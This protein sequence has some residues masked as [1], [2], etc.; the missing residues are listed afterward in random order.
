MLQFQHRICSTKCFAILL[1]LGFLT[2]GFG[3]DGRASLIPN[4]DE[5]LRKTSTAFAADAAQRTYPADAP[6][7]GDAVGRVEVSYGIKAMELANLSEEDWNNVE[8]WVNHEY[9]VFVPLIPKKKDGEG[10]RHL[11]FQMLYNKKGEH[12]PIGLIN[13]SIRVDKVEILRDGK[14]YNVPFQLA[15]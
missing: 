6:K 9:V 3:C 12:L 11:N 10:V 8:V 5:S 4:K 7:G 1:G 13:S 15:E 14:L 2:A